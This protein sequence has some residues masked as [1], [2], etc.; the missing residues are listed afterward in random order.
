MN[1]GQSVA[2]VPA[3]APPTTTTLP[4]ARIFSY[5]PGYGPLGIGPNFSCLYLYV[6][7]AKLLSAKMIQ[8]ANPAAGEDVCDT[9]V[10]PNPANLGM[11]L[12]IDATL[13]YGQDPEL[14]FDQLKAIDSPYN[15]Y[16]H[17]GLPPTPIAN[18]GRASIRAAM[19]PAPNPTADD[20][21][22]QGLAPG[23]P[24]EYLYYVLAGED[25]HHA[26]AAT[27][28]QHEANVAA[29]AAAGLLS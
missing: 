15:T 10:D 2:L 8:V 22:C 5:G 25:G 20:P 11:P 23:E 26:F 18:P 13:F 28:A 29:A 14:P 27:Q 17:T 12:Q 4:V 1:V 24:C 9:A 3:I 6:D 7:D 19:N 21:I 16:L